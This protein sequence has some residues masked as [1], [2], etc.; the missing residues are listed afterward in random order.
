MAIDSAERTAEQVGI[1]YFGHS[2]FLWTTP[3]GVRI[4][5]DPYGD[6][7]ED[8]RLFPSYGTPESSRWFLHPFPHVRCDV[9]LVTHPHFDH[10][11]IERVE[12]SPTI[13]RDPLELRV[14]DV[15]IRGF[16]GKHAGPFGKEFGQRNVIFIIEVAGITFC[17]LGDN[18]VELPEEMQNFVEKIDVLMVTVDDNKHLLSYEAVEQLISRL[19]PSIIMP[20]H[21]LIPGLTD[22]ASTLGGIMTWLA[23]RP[24]VRPLDSKSINLSASDLPEQQEIWVFDICS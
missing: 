20:T 13:L 4:L 6:P 15:R 12:D 14:D 8:S 10:D 21:Y 24:S 5:I 2:S 17:H 1:R 3:A 9:L 18:Q 23:E 11:A 19:R 22:P 7:Y 16:M